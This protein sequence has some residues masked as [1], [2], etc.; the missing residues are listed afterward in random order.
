MRKTNS[1]GMNFVCFERER[2][3]RRLMGRMRNESDGQNSVISF[4]IKMERESQSSRFPT[5]I[6]QKNGVFLFEISFF[7]LEILTFCYYAN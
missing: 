2:L 7:V 6:I 1:R 4:V 3:L 5:A